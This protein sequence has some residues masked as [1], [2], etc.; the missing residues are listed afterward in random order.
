[1]N[2]KKIKAL[3]ITKSVFLWSIVVFALTMMIFTIVAVTTLNRS[4]REIFGYKVYIVNTNSMAAT[5][6]DA[7]SIVFVK[8]VDPTTLQEGDIIT[9]LSQ[10]PKKLGQTITHKIRSLTVDENGSPA[11]VTYGTTTD[12]DDETVVTYPF[13]LGKY[14]SHVPFLGRLFNF[15]KSVPGY[16]LC[17]LLPFSVIII[18]E[19]A[20]LFSQIRTCKKEQVNEMQEERTKLQAEMAENA[21]MLEELR[22]LK[23]NFSVN[24]TETHNE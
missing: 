10:D 9:F 13:I 15:L 24:N 14:E 8:E 5:D 21:K 2:E 6:F 20:T 4:Q 7:G 12:T 11:F 18:S 19:A 1:M 23:A 3:K 16:L 17:V 22:A